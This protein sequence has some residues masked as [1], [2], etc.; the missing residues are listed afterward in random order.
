MK[1]NRLSPKPLTVLGDSVH[2][3][4]APEPLL[5]MWEATQIVYFVQPNAEL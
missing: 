1:H 2:H 3:G 5:I 4:D